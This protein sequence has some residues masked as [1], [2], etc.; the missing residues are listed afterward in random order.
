MADQSHPRY[1]AFLSHNTADKPAVEELARRLEQDGISCFLDKWH[2]IPGEPWQVAL[3]EALDQSE[4]CVVFV[5]PSGLGPW[6]NEEMRAAIA[7]RVSTSSHRVVP[8]LLPGGQREQRSRLPTFLVSAMWVEFQK[9]TDEED[10]YHRLKCGI[11]GV[12]PGPSMG[13]ALFEGECP[14]RGLQV[15]DADHA[16]FFFGRDAE[17]D[18]ILDRLAED[19]GTHQ[20]GRFLGVV[21][22]SGSGKSSLVRAGLIPAI[23]EGRSR[24]G[25]SLPDSTEWPIVTLKP[26]TDPLKALADA[27]WS[28][29]VARPLVRDPLTFSEQL[30]E[31]EVRLHATIE[32]LLTNTP[33]SRRFVIV[34]DQFEELFTQCDD[35]AQRQAFIDNLINWDFVAANLAKA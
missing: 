1:Q 30:L 34:V 25:K 9:S 21:G 23:R 5:G 29:E 2:L 13:E 11:R 10:G 12:A 8:V 24:S 32:T 20:E 22:A 4:C 14:Y 19:F 15:F 18:W 33:E 3:E 6:Q 31:K 35:E 28:N 7:R 16:R 17:V 27:F 26:G